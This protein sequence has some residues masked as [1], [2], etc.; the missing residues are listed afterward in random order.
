MLF[1]IL[2]FVSTFIA[3]EMAQPLAGYNPISSV[4][5]QSLI[6]LDQR[7]IQVYLDQRAIE[8]GMAEGNVK[9]DL[10]EAMYNQG[11][12]SESYAE[13]TFND[14]TSVGL[15]EFVAGG[16]AMRGISR[17]GIQVKGNALADTPA[18]SFTLMF[19]YNVTTDPLPCYVGGLPETS[20]AT[21]GCL[22]DVGSIDIADQ[23]SILYSYDFQIDN[24][25][26]RTFAGFSTSAKALMHDCD[27]C[28][29][30]TYEKFIQ[31]Y[32]EYD[33]GHQIINA[34]FN[35]DKTNLKNGNH[36]F[37]SRYELGVPGMCLSLCVVWAQC[38]S[39]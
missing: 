16:T 8:E 18:G 29:Y 20:Q 10:A 24:M 27:T 23:E 36:D 15:P 5:D 39:F 12:H 34:A 9:F 17:S 35:Q 21:G 37:S 13:V 32:G 25:N 38:W 26:A 14:T 33:Y 3:P 1:R 30:K 4:R 6:D 19:Q 31:Y 28:P 7:A 11:A 22:E 2:V